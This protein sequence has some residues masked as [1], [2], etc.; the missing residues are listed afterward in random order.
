M[1]RHLMKLRSIPG[2]KNAQWYLD[3]DAEYINASAKYWSGFR[4]KTWP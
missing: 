3:P 1:K 4:L 2:R